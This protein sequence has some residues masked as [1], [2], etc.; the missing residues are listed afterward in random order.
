MST[1]E[2]YDDYFKPGRYLAT[3]RAKN[4]VVT[5]SV[6]F[7]TLTEAMAYARTQ[8]TLGEAIWDVSDHLVPG[9]W[10]TKMFLWLEKMAPEA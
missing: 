4:G 9:K 1:W 10:Y 3:K 7:A 8:Q 2:P 5:S 6:R